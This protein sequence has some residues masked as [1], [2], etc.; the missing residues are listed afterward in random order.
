MAVSSL[1]PCLR[2]AAKPAAMASSATSTPTTPAMP[3]TTTDEEPS[4]CGMV[5][6]PTCVADQAWRPVRVASSHS[7]SGSSSSGQRPAGQQRQHHQGR[8]HHGPDAEPGR[9]GAS[10]DCRAC[11]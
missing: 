1:P 11:S 2:V 9:A 5:A 8:D 6:M 7:A 3:T 4:R 10:I